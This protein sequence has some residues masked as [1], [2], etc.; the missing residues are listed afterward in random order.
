MD[1][2]R[3]NAP[4]DF[5]AEVGRTLGGR[6]E[7]ALVRADG[8]DF[9]ALTLRTRTLAALRREEAGASPEEDAE[10]EGEAEVAEGEADDDDA[11]VGVTT[12]GRSATGRTPSGRMSADFTEGTTGVLCAPRTV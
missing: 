12:A 10:V 8:D 11:I 7:P 6:T 3:S 2:A 1:A 9:A 5:A 4:I